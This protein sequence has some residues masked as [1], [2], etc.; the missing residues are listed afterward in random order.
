MGSQ[1]GSKGD[2]GVAGSRRHIGAALVPGDRPV[3]LA[4]LLA[5][6]SI[7]ADLGFGLPPEEAMRSCLIAVGLAR[8]L[9][10][11]ERDVSDIFYTT[12]LEHVGCNGFAHETAIVFGD[13]LV[14]NAA[15]A[16]TNV[17]DTRDGLV[18]FLPAVMRGRPLLARARLFVFTMTQ[19]SQF[20]RR[21]AAAACE[22]G[23]ATARRLGLP[24]R[25]QRALDEVF[26]SWNGSGGPRG[27]QRDDIALASRFARLGATA[28]RFDAIGGVAVAVDSVAQR[29]GGLLDPE[30]ASAFADG[31][32]AILAE[33]NAGDPQAAVIAAEPEPAVSVPAAR[34]AEVASAFGDVADLKSPFM[35]GHSSVVGMLVRDAG[36]RLGLDAGEIDRLH[37]AGLLHDIGRVGISDLIWESPRALTIAEWES[38]RLHPYHSER[39]LA[40]SVALE[41]MAV[42]VG[43]HHERQDG[44]GYHRGS[45]SREVPFAARVLAAAD[46]YN[47]MTQARTYRAAL[48]AETAAERVRE[49]A[50]AGRLDGDAAAAVLEAAGQA[51]SRRRAVLPAGLSEREL[52]VLRAV[53]QGLSNREIAQA[54]TI[55]PRTAEHHVQHIYTKIGVS[56]RAAAAL[57]AMEHDLLDR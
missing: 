11:P 28:A 38:V 17:A 36:V 40:G 46:A 19:G 15:A 8:S 57:F 50:G 24:D 33:V 20:D 41:P 49:E 44:S 3:R 56:S 22:V 30:I 48:P 27:L 10:L 45:R 42:I 39:I 12:L 7:V 54:F 43:M 14:A 21:F 53:A 13:E 37:V 5:S 47:A 52:E 6:L 16:R 51:S 9:G 35:H 18:T 1:T 4:D 55:S 23:R 25:V 34:L 26:E 32:K 31:A 29:S 2:E